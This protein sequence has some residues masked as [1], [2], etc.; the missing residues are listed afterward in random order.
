MTRT[1]DTYEIRGGSE[2]ALVATE[3]GRTL[4]VLGQADVA[5]LEHLAAALE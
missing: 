5:E 1:W 3:P 2:R 4:I